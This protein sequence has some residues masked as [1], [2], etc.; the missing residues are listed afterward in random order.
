MAKQTGTVLSWVGGISDGS[1]LGIPDSFEFGRSV[2]F[3]SDPNKLTILPKTAKDSGSVVVDL[4]KWAERIQGGTDTYFYGDTGNLYKRDSSSVWSLEH[5]AGASSG[6]GLAYFG[7]DDFLYFAQDKT[8]GRYGPI[9]STPAWYDDFLSSEGGAPT[10]TNSVDLELD[11]SQHA[12]RADT[13]SLSITG[14]LTLEDYI[15][16][17]SLP[18]SGSIM[19]LISKWDESGTTRSYIMDVK[20]TSASFGDGGDGALTVAADTTDAPTD[21]SASGTLGTKSLA[22]TNTSFA[23]GQKVLIHQTRGTN[24]GVKQ[25]TEIESYIAGTITTVDNLDIS[26]SSTGSNKAQVLVFKEYTNITIN[27]GKTLTAKAWNGTVGGIIAYLASGTVTI[28]GT[29]SANGGD[30]SA[31]TGTPAGGTGGGFRGG[32]GRSA[33]PPPGLSQQGEGTSGTQSES[34]SANGSGG[35]GGQISGANAAD[36]GGGGNGTTGGTGNGRKGSGSTSDTFIGGTGGS[37][38]G[39]ADLT[40]L[41]FG[42]GG[43]GGCVVHANPSGGGGSGGGIIFLAGA[44]IAEITGSITANG[45][46]GGNGGGADG[47]GGAG[48]SV[49]L[50]SQTAT[51]GTN[52]ITASGGSGPD[53]AG[54][55]GD[56]RIHLDYSSSFTGTTNPTLDSAQDDNLSVTSGWQLR[57][58]VSSDGDDSEFLVWDITD[59]ISTTVWAR[60]AISWDASGSLARFYKDGV[61]LGTY[62]GTF[63][64]IHDN[65]SAFAIGANENS[66]GSM[67]NFFDGKKDDVRVWNDIRSASELLKWNDQVLVGT[68]ANLV[69][70]YKLDGDYEDAQSSGLNDLTAS[71]SP[72][73]STDVPFSGVTTRASQDQ[74][75]DTSGNTYALTTAIDEGATHRQTFVPAKDPQKSIEVNIAAIGTG[76]WTLA[77]HDAL[78]REVATK[79][80]VNADL[81]TGLF[82]FIFTP[83]RPVIGA[84]YH[85]HLTSTVADGTVVSTDANDLETGEFFSHYQFLVTD[86]DF[87]PMAQM[88]NFLVIGNDRYVAKWEGLTSANYDPHAITLPSGYRIRCFG[89]WREYLAIGTWQ[90]TS[91]TDFDRGRI[92]FWDGTNETYNSYIDVPEGGVNALLGTKGLLYIWAGYSGD[93]LLYQGGDAAQKIKRLPKITTDKYVEIFPGAVSMWRTLVHFGVAGNSDSTVIEKGAYTWGSLNR[94]YQDALG[95]DYPLSLGTRT[96][97]NLKVGMVTGVGQELLIGWQNENAYGVDA[98]TVSNDPFSEGTVELLISDLADLPRK[99]LPLVA[100]ADFEALSSGESVKIKYKADRESNYSENDAE[101][102]ADATNTRMKVGE[103]VNEIQVSVDLLTTTTTSPA[104]TGITLEREAEEDSRSA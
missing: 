21:S 36:G 7:E 19:T 29:I 50:K 22:A 52:K 62:T 73:F 18:A 1:K 10:N 69:A 64:G 12:S 103:Q 2:D 60:W 99:K 40:T 98:V 82:E 59:D 88:L 9:G 54:D 27:S 24:A 13:A 77:V 85:F 34:T 74:A 87:H 33:N 46:D 44:T 28:T 79:T 53:L 67:A 26:F 100:R 63:T 95:Y 66:G 55:G 101:D 91:I 84:S 90:G 70:Y 16:P 30:G 48:G 11:S 65:A 38:S 4:P 47:G 76:D 96:G 94:N 15:N 72:V 71:G 57:L 56:G 32:Y 104:L 17:E 78:N 89:F 5:T 37:T 86:T 49:L 42:G 6:N 45:G 83:W 41:T 8:F 23:A 92:F 93:L 68:E 39:T 61:E 31:G 102:T 43:G 75:L 3:R 25:K 51:L 80:A 20:G 14:D 97:T 81:N 58:G 35:G